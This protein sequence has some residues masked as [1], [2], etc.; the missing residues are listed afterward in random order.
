MQNQKLINHVTSPSMHMSFS[1]FVQ[2][3]QEMERGQYPLTDKQA[4]T[5]GVATKTLWQWKVNWP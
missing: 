2:E 1:S 3:H 4:S 5:V